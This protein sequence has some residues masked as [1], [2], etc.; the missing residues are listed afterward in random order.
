MVEIM[1]F[2]SIEYDVRSVFFREDNFLYEGGTVQGSRWKD[3]EQFCI[4]LS[5]LLPGMRWAIEARADNLLQPASSGRSRLDV[6]V[7]AGLTGIYVGVESGSDA[8]LKLY[9]KGQTVN[10]ISE[11]I[12]ACAIRGVAV[13]TTVC[14][15]DPDVFLRRNYPL[16]DLT[17]GRYLVSLR[18]QRERILRDSRS[19]M[20]K[21]EIPHERREE[22]ALVGIPVS[23]IY[24]VLARESA[25][26]PE[27][28]EHF[29]P[30]SRYIYPKGF[31]WW[32]EHVYELKR[33]VRPLI[34]YEFQA[35]E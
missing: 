23:A 11:A 18:G 16:I 1:R 10:T 5:E 24:K 29:D 33:R 35:A 8:M 3:V 28:V 14:Y 2:L 7:G 22:Y 19:F 26:F 17:D 6:L 32:A 31:R 20:D 15:G 9:V 25:A 30:I 12:R 27:L 4:E 21:H 34:S 13:V